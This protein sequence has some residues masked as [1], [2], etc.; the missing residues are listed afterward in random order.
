MRV[1]LPRKGII[2]AKKHRSAPTLRAIVGYA[3]SARLN[4]K[5]K[6]SIVEIAKR[7]G[8]PSLADFVGWLVRANI[9][10]DKPTKPSGKGDGLEVAN[11]LHGS[12]EHVFAKTLLA[13]LKS[14]YG[15]T[16]PEWFAV[17]ATSGNKGLIG[18]LA[19]RDNYNPKDSAAVQS[20]VIDASFDLDE[21]E[22]PTDG[23]GETAE[24]ETAKTPA[25][26]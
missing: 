4:E 23:E 17:K 20:H 24:T 19:A 5:R 3:D 10:L 14:K 26:K 12:E 13:S 15:S 7:F 21:T 8:F 16:K 22:W 18:S 9:M 2:M 6:V 1:I 25:A 11:E